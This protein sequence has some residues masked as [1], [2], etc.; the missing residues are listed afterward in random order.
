M[1]HSITDSTCEALGPLERVGGAYLR[2]KGG[3]R[4]ERK[5]RAPRASKARL[6]RADGHAGVGNF[7]RIGDVLRRIVDRIKPATGS[8]KGETKD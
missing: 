8:A 3:T 6:E 4:L 2:K 1:E 5:R 7:E